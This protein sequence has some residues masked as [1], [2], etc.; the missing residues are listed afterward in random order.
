MRVFMNISSDTKRKFRAAVYRHYRAHKRDLLW[1]R[2]KDP[3]KILVSEIM[4]QQTQVERVTQKYPLFIK[5]FRDFHALD[6]ATVAEVLAEWRGLGYNRRALLL[7]KIARIIVTEYKGKLPKDFEQLQKLPGIGRSTAGGVCAFAFN[8][9]VLFIETNIRRVYIHHFF[10]GKK[11]VNDAAVLSLLEQTMD[12]KDPRKWYSALMDYGSTLGK[13]V[14]N[15]NRRSA[16]YVRQPR[17][18][19]SRRQLRG[20]ILSLLSGISGMDAQDIARHFGLG[21]ASVN[22]VLVILKREGFLTSRSDTWSIAG[23]LGKS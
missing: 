13:T 20:K 3:Y 5:R 17:F 1:R 18:E 23:L 12:Q 21:M 4:L 6:K 19:G 9:P 16:H 7:K 22:E 8:M 15:P 14:E 11:G 10:L 2:T